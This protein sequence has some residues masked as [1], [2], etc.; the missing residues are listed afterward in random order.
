MRY[1][2][3][4]LLRKSGLGA[5]I[6]LWLALGSGAAQAQLPVF[7]TIDWLLDRGN[8][9]FVGTNAGI[10]LRPGANNINAVTNDPGYAFPRFVFPRTFDLT[11]STTTPSTLIVDNRNPADPANSQ[12][13]T[14]KIV[15]TFPAYTPQTGLDPQ[16]MAHTV[17][18][19]AW[20]LPNVP[21]DRSVNDYRAPGQ[22]YSVTTD[23]TQTYS[24]DY[25]FTLATHDDFLV[26]DTTGQTRPATAQELANLPY[27]NYNIYAGIHNTLINDT[28]PTAVTSSGGQ[29]LLPGNYSIDIYSPGDGTNIGGV[30]H[31]NVTRA[32]VRVSWFR[33]VDA[34]GNFIQANI[35]NPVTSRIYEVDLGQVG[36]IPIQGGGNSQALFPYDGDP[37]DQITV[38][39]YTISPDTYNAN[40]DPIFASAPLITA[41]AVRF[42]GHTGGG[43]GL[44]PISSTGRILGPVASTNKLLFT[45]GGTAIADTQPL[46]FFAREESVPNT[47]AT[48]P[49]DPTQPVSTTN[50]LIPDPTAT[51]TVP[52]FY[53]IDSR[54]DNSIGTDGDGFIP[55]ID[56]VRWRYVGLADA[57]NLTGTSV[58]SPA[59]ANVRC[60]DGQTRTIVYFLTTNSA[61]SLGHIYA[62][63]AAGDRATLTT[64]NYWIYP[65]YR[66]LT[67]AETT[68][69]ITTSVQHDPNYKNFTAGPYPAATWG[70]DAADPFFH[71]DGEIIKDPTT[72]GGT[73]VRSDTLLPAF[74]GIAGSPVIMDDPSNGAGAQMLVVGG[75]NGRVYAFDAGGRGDFNPADVTSTG[76]TQRIW[77]W[78]HFGADAYYAAGLTG[79]NKITDETSL[80][81]ILGSVSYDTN[82]NGA[83]PAAR[84]LFVPGGDGRLYAIN[85]PHDVLLSYNAGTQ[86]ATW[87]ERRNWVY[88]A[89]DQA[90]GLGAALSTPAIFTPTG[91]TFPNI[92]FTCAG[93]AYALQEVPPVIAGS[94]IT[95]NALKW[96]FPPTANPPAVDP[97]NPNSGPL[98]P[99]FDGNAPLLMSQA[100]LNGTP[101][102][103]G[104][105]AVNNDYCYVLQSNGGIYGLDASTGTL[106]ASGATLSGASTVTSPIGTRLTGLVTDAAT[107]DEQTKPEA[108]IVFSD[109]Q[110]TIY[111][112][113]ARPDTG[114]TGPFGGTY[115]GQVW[116]HSDTS[117]SRVAPAALANG[118]IF[119]G[120]TNGQLRAYGPGAG[121]TIAPNEPTEV[122]PGANGPITIDI[123]NLNVFSKAVYDAIGTTTATIL[124]AQNG[125]T[126][127]H[128][129]DP[130]GGN[131]GD[132]SINGSYYTDWGEYIYVVAAG[133]Y[134]AQPQDDPAS[135]A[136]GP[137]QITVTFTLT[138]GGS[139]VRT[140]NVP[141]TVKAVHGNGSLWPD[142]PGV[143]GG[144][145]DALSIGGTDI[146]TGPGLQQGPQ[147]N[148]Y[149]WTAKFAIPVN[150]N[151][152]A[153]PAN[154][155]TG[156]NLDF[157]PYYN[158]SL[159]ASAQISQPGVNGNAVQTSTTMRAG[160]P[161]FAGNQAGDT[162][163]PIAVQGRQLAT[164]RKIGVT[165]PIAVSTRGINGADM[166]GLASRNAIGVF[167]SINSPG[168]PANVQE[169]LGN[170]NDLVNPTTGISSSGIPKAVFAPLPMVQDGGTSNYQ[171]VDNAGNAVQAFYVIDRSNI[172]AMTGKNLTVQI[173]PNN[174]KWHG[175]APSANPGV[176][177]SSVMNA[178]PWELLP[179]DGQDSLDYPSIPANSIVFAKTTTGES[180]I[181]GRTALI[182]ATNN[183]DPKLRTLNPTPFTLQVKVPRFQPANINYGIHT[184]GGVSF[185][186]TF[187]DMSGNNRGATSAGA[188]YDRHILGPL[189]NSTGDQAALGSGPVYPAGGYISNFDVNLI[190]AT[191]AT[192]ATVRTQVTFN[193][194]QAF[195]NTA[196][197][198]ANN[199]DSLYTHRSVEMGL[200]VPPSV[201]MRVAETTLDQGK[202]PH[203]LGYTPLT[204]T[205]NP[206]SFQVP[207]V[208]D[209]SSP[210]Q[211][212]GSY[213][214]DPN[215][216][217]QF[218]LPFTLYNESNINLVDV[219]VAKALGQNFAKIDGNAVSQYVDI[220]NGLEN[221]AEVASLQFKSDQVNSLSVNPLY[222]LPFKNILGANG[223]GNAGLI[224][225]FD[226]GSISSNAGLY[227]E[228]SLWPLVNPFVTAADIT[229]AN[230]NYGAMLPTTNQPANGIAAWADGAQPQPTIGKPRPGDTTGRVATVPDQPYSG[231][232]VF[233]RPRIAMSVPLGTP[234]GTYSATVYP[235][236]D[237]TPIQWKEWL[238]TYARPAG[239]S[240]NYPVSHDGILNVSKAGTPIESHADPTFIL[241]AT[242]R[243]AKLS[244]DPTV[245]DL[246]ML[247]M[248]G[249][250]NDTTHG[251]FTPPGS[252][253][254]PAAYMAPGTGGNIYNRNLF[255]YWPTNRRKSPD[256]FIGANG[257]PSAFAPYT[258]AYSS[259]LAPYSVVS[260]SSPAV[261]VGDFDFAN[262][263]GL[264]G[265]GAPLSAWWNAPSFNQ[266][267]STTITSLFPTTASG[268]I[269]G[270]PGTPN[271]STMRLL[272]PAIASSLDFSG[273][274]GA[275]NV[276]DTEAY[277]FWPGQVDKSSGTNGQ[278][279]QVRDSRI[280][281]ISLN[282]GATPGVPTG[283]TNIMPNDPTVT[284]LAPRPLLVKLPAANGAP[285]QKFLYVFW[286]QGN[287]SNTSIYYNAMVGGIAA[288][289]F[290]Q[291]SGW[292][293][294]DMPLP[295]S[296]ALVWQ[297]DPAPVYRH[298]QYP[299]GSATYEDVIDVVYTGVLKG[300]QQ[301]ETLLSRYKINRKAPVNPGDPPIGTLTL[302]PVREQAVGEVM[303]RIGST[304]TFQAQD[305]G[306]ALGSGPQGTVL[307]SDT[308]GKIAIYR[309]PGGLNNA[310]V[311]LNPQPA[312][313]NGSPQLGR[314]DQAS[315][316]LYFDSIGGGQIVVDMRSGTIRFPQVAPPLSDRIMVSYIPYVMRLN[317]SRDD[318]NIDRT[319][320]G[321]FGNMALAPAF[322][323]TASVASSGNNTNP[324][325][326]FD[327]APNP[328]AQLT[329]PQVVFPSGATPT[330]DRLWVLYRKN[331]P[332]GV[333]K[334]TIYYKSMRLTL[335]LPFPVK[336]GAPAA[337]GTQQLANV[338]V[339]NNRGPYEVDWVR[340]RIY[341]TEADENNVIQ[342]HYTF[343][344]P[345][346]TSTGDTG[347]MTYRV[348][349]ADEI[350]AS[351]QQADQT[352]PEVVL[353]TDSAVSEGQV[354]AFKDPFLDKLWVFWS[355]TRAGSTDLYF[356]T[357]APQFYPTASGQR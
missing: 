53:C 34:N 275:P 171:A 154:G 328:R 27:V 269:P 113:A 74:P 209:M 288:P 69:G 142:D 292:V 203:G 259:V 326:I 214:D 281:W 7:D 304:N 87:Q 125:G 192:N 266:Y 352:T 94:G 173:T 257:L 195:S 250:W 305:A 356:E 168:L 205:T 12:D 196:A 176:T 194:A 110:G 301:V 150:P 147:N 344:D 324:V 253:N 37:R 139:M 268:N 270:L 273:G 183:G 25:G 30:I 45:S 104:A 92:Y 241:K 178:L 13:T 58:A 63:D 261:V 263:A 229:S 284:K 134:H 251:F 96:V 227:P 95:V 314:Y 123:R 107:A 149:P 130:I 240:Q 55:S 66:P 148:V 10:P 357:I 182:G 302:I 86:R 5:L 306:W 28:H 265:S 339:V 128:T 342:L 132:T 207:F 212:L 243:E 14:G 122:T 36:W 186:S 293:G 247:D 159:T 224:S 189:I 353:P 65:S 99:G 239:V 3:T 133:V 180:A 298:I 127:T 232:A 169:L 280:H 59:I 331:D 220:T 221:T 349:W 248:F 112:F 190:T 117:A 191:T 199:T 91:G 71:Y 129:K 201:K 1:R 175:W 303:T 138:N 346:S 18:N 24:F 46:T 42:T 22:G 161:N 319:L 64:Q 181:S 297:S 140:V 336:L 289:P 43:T 238:S 231:T 290:T 131:V 124:K 111:G 334:S 31:P 164:A 93:R 76:T 102:L 315:G 177:G 187:L 108:A 246:S 82:Y 348:S 54:N 103:V 206:R 255:L 310:S 85:P 309:I 225:S 146:V 57:G 101:A 165:N 279:T 217:G 204:D 307:P 80:G 98:S 216:G 262:K 153:S 208:P 340:G 135:G 245:G 67:V 278:I 242:V 33:T 219:R 106:L 163:V 317:T 258:M 39:I 333:A 322:K 260:G 155:T 200:S 355:S 185:G 137:P 115:L 88:P 286:H 78:P 254:F 19:G 198:N 233:Q 61:G 120:D 287:Q 97:A 350:S 44:G 313:N 48:I 267:D 158:Y 291:T 329:S 237:S 271:V 202:V 100:T 62:F 40:G 105:P 72:A 77:T 6:A 156:G 277:L 109:I 157:K 16:S 23:Y 316:L 354:S 50:P 56:R 2:S 81:T 152:A 121:P 162:G 4:L 256:G 17:F 15:R 282:G 345:N 167:P 60:R 89:L 41:D 244:R 116:H 327:R 70:A 252:D 160:I 226:H 296:G 49:T 338:V 174:L 114:Y 126:L 211:I 249:S 321:N 299:S 215:R 308:Q 283:P 143:T 234:V 236:E 312:P 166:T 170:G 222:A 68:A 323:P 223:V 141:A 332:S 264:T 179:T 341:F 144:E 213:W 38:T 311:L 26:T 295:T 29:N 235:Y 294:G 228:R 274:Y 119:E 330:I 136:T 276:N 52:V 9:S 184:F 343:Y 172:L 73:T 83:P 347:V 272:H 210:A 325:A 197:T 300:R 337:N 8:V 51:V 32:L 285:A 335:K 75:I 21:A 84:P 145:H 35:N 230:Q 151:A 118:Y 79:T 320:A 193:L 218:F 20:T 90:G 351:I 11:G 318:S 47:S 188:A